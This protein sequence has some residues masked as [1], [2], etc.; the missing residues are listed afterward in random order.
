MPASAAFLP[1]T[2]GVLA[3]L[4]DP[5]RGRRALADAANRVESEAWETWQA[6]LGGC[7]CPV[8][9]RFPGRL[10]RLSGAVRTATG[11]D[12]WDGPGRPHRDRT[13]RYQRW[14]TEALAD[15]DGAG[16]AEA[17][18]GYDAALAHAMLGAV[19]RTGCSGADPAGADAPTGRVGADGA[20]SYGTMTGWARQ[21]RA[22]TSRAHRAASPLKWATSRPATNSSRWSRGS[23]SAG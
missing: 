15:G 4:P 23:R 14:L 8:R 11:A 13:G 10:R 20:R 5:S 16:F 17:F 22:A 6:L 7:S 19:S 3:E 21:A 9:A 1:L 12:W 18:A 2:L